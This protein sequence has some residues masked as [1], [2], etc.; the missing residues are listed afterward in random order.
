MA[1]NNLI[2]IEHA[3]M[4]L[5]NFSGKAD[6]YTP[7]GKRSF[8]VLISQETA[9]AMEEAGIAVKYLQPRHDEDVPIPWVK[10]KVNMDRETNP[11]KIYLARKEDDNIVV[12]K[13][14]PLKA[15]TV[16]TLDYLDIDEIETQLSVYEW[17]M[18][19]GAS[20]KALYLQTLICVLDE[21]DF[22]SRYELNDF[23]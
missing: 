7:E 8:G 11:P 15:D 10:V 1:R 18:P 2:T 5:R 14:N 19:N 3:K 9:D 17:Q 6:K 20:G 4:I 13:D 22:M 23:N 21:D 16:G 12:D